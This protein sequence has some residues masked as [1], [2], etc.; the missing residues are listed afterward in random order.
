MEKTPVAT[1]LAAAAA[2]VKVGIP[3]WIGTV[4]EKRAV[5]IFALLVAFVSL[6]FAQGRL[7]GIDEAIRSVALELSG[8]IA[9]GARVAVVSSG[10]WHT[11][12]I[13]TDGSLWAWESNRAGK[14]GD[15]T[16]GGIRSSSVRIGWATDWVYIA[17]GF[18]HTMVVKNDGTLWDW[19]SSE[20]GQLGVGRSHRN[21]LAWVMQH[22][23]ET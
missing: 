22:R 11:T 23:R 10:S 20:M 4:V 15:G 2:R 12:V 18:S 8:R 19:G 14:L 13:R 21:V 16:T 1:M 7:A 9:N 6:A 3:R 17:A 5:P